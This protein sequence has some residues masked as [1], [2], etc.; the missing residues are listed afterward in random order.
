[1]NIDPLLTKKEVLQLTKMSDTTL[2]RLRR[3]GDF[4][5]P[6][7]TSTNS[8]RWHQSSIHKYLENLKQQNQ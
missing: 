3:N 4:P 1:M 2:W 5:N 6:V 8:I 7:K